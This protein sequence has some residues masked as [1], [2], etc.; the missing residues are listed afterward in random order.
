MVGVFR[1][2]A[3]EASANRAASNQIIDLAQARRI[4]AIL[5]SE[6]SRLRRSTQD[7]LD[8]LNRLAGWKTA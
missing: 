5:V 4:G 3:S 2:T 6:L 8:T 7:L 1:E